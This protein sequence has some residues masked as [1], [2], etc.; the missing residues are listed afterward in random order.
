MINVGYGEDLSIR[1]LAF[2]IRDIVGLKGEIVFDNSKPD[3]IPRKFL[4][5]SRLR[6]TDWA[7]KINLEEGIRQTYRWYRKH[8]KRGC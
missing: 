6:K 7:P 4:D 3:G 2:L 8:I 5:S 1:E